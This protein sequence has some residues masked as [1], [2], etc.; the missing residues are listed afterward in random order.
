MT[1]RELLRAGSAM[2]LLPFAGGAAPAGP[3]RE[4]VIALGGMRFGPVPSGIRAGDTI[5]WVN[6]DMVPHTATA[7]DGSFDLNLPAGRSSRMTVQ[8]RGSFAFYCRFHPGMRGTL[9]A[10]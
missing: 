7:R 1:R 8:R 6:R 5:L 10:A 9:A 4:H 3:R 2:L